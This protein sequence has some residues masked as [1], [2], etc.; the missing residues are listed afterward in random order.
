M[1]RQGLNLE[2][3]VLLGRTL[4]EYTRF[5]ALDLHSL[6]GRRVLDVA[7]GVSSFC[8]EASA[9]GVQTTGFDRI[10]EFS[11]AEIQS[12]CAP[13]LDAVTRDIARA[14][15]YNWEFYKSPD[16]MRAYRERAYKTFLADYALHR[17]TRYITGSLPQLPFADGQ[18]DVTL[19]SYLLFVYEEHFDYEFH[20]R[21]ILE[22]LRV[23]RDEVRCYPVVTFE[24]KP[25]AHL[26]RLMADPDLQ[27][28]RF[29]IHPTT[30]EFLLGSNRV[31]RISRR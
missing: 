3:V 29:E 12:R 30:F 27:G 11:A 7:S 26:E 5:F 28:F 9:A 17:G 6:R 18:F 4:D 14:R 10:Y 2:K 15:T 21:S 22:M 19:T 25:S 16:G 8:A 20:K 23:T 13:D 1:S 24:A 31:L